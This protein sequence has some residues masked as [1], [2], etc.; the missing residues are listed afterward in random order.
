VVLLVK[1]SETASTPLP[2]R[3]PLRRRAALALESALALTVASLAA[4]V[5]S[6][7]V[8]R[9]L[10]RPVPAASAPAGGTAGEEA[11]RVGRAVERIAAVLPWHPVCLPQAIAARAML[12]RRRI[13]S[14]AHLGMRTDEP[15]EAHAW[16]TVG[17][18]V[19]QGAP[20]S[21]VVP[22]LDLW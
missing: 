11:V 4:R 15:T 13:E 3:R 18:T 12:R 6:D 20:I 22:L 21:E 10:G 1:R 5:L 14:L 16:V 2:A 19:V 7:R 17:R 9:L 8:I